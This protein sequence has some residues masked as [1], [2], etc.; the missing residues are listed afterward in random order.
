MQNALCGLDVWDKRTE[1]RW[2]WTDEQQSK[3]PHPSC[4]RYKQIKSKS[5][6]RFL[7]CNLHLASDG[8]LIRIEISNKSSTEAFFVVDNSNFKAGLSINSPWLTFPLFPQD[9][10]LHQKFRPAPPRDEG[11]GEIKA[12]QQL[13]C[14]GNLA[15]YLNWQ[16]CMLTKHLCNPKKNIYNILTADL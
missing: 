1:G 4:N 9:D 5:V 7:N 11:W 14:F 2:F 10:G 3:T 12:K 15:A 13:L 6:I 8:F 16:Q